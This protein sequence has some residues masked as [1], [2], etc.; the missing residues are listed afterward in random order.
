MA[1]SYEHVRL[2][3]KIAT[4]TAEGL[5][6][7]RLHG[8]EILVPATV[9][10][11]YCEL[12]LQEPFVP[13]GRRRPAKLLQLITPSPER[14]DA[15]DVCPLQGQC[16]GCPLGL[17]TEKAQLERKRRDIAS[18]LKRAGICDLRVPQVMPA[19]GG[20]SRFKSVRYFANTKEGLKNGFYRA[21]SHE[22]CPAGRCLRECAWFGDFAAALCSLAG[23]L[24]LEA[25][26]EAQNRGALR[27]LLL[28][29]CGT[30]G[31]LA[32]LSHRGALPQGAEDKF[33]DLCE[34]F[35]ITSGWLQRHDA[36]GNAVSKGELSCLTGVREVTAKIG[37]YRFKAGPRTFLQVNPAQAQRL[38][39]AA[40]GWCGED[41]EATGL[42]LCCGAGTMTLPLA[43]RFKQAIGV[44]IV[45]EAVEAARGNAELNG[46]ANARFIAADLKDVLGSLADDSVRAVIADPSRR[47]LG[48]DNCKA[49]G[50]L[51]APVRLAMIFCALKALERDLPALRAQGFTVR[52]VQGF[53]MFPH[54]AGVETLVLLEKA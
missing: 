25:Y 9:G 53:D 37:A 17:L 21:R 42:D 11:D 50:A 49:L 39:E 24:G 30:G 40:L 28:R 41:Q 44:E 20:V 43:A 1:A 36:A 54:T 52:G 19:P 32:V 48:A 45:K 26:D 7:L 8:E 23:E 5:G 12:E 51:K 35:E 22:V 10:G 46:I 3:A 31:R 15:A 18:A 16:G 2:K 34:R 4:V 33:R 29:D 13:G 14:R 47:G 38:Y 6:E 27:S